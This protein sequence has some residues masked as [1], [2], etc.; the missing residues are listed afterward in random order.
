MSLI[1]SH[2]NL[3]HAAFAE[4][5]DAV[6]ARARAAGVSTMLTICDTLDNAP[7]VRAIAEQH[8]FI[9]A[10]VGVHPHHAKDYPDLKAETLM[11]LAEHPKIV[12]IGETGLDQHYGYSSLDDQVR[13]LRAHIAAARALDL[14]V[15]I[16]TREAD[17][18]TGDVLE[19]EYARGA[20]RILMHCYT[21]GAR[22]A[23][24]A[25]ALGACFSISGIATF[26]SASDV[27]T[28]M[29]TVPLANLILETDC[30]YLAPIPHRGR[31]NEPAFL[32]DLSRFVAQWRGWEEGAMQAA[33]ADNFYALFSRARRP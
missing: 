10:S 26:K 18:A 32:A 2:V 33:M 30:P 27:R 20:F 9:W 5:R 21:S 19:D 31:R 24:R 4:D 13:S 15:I 11:R 23:E 12:A 28:V 14:P 25:L 7:V 8:D 29:E 22:L 16:H 6:I 1:D 17:D 3:H